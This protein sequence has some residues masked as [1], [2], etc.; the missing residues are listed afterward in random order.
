MK[1]RSVLLALLL[2]VL[3]TVASTAVSAHCI[4]IE[5]PA[6]IPGDTETL[7]TAFYAHPDEAM[8]ERELTSLTLFAAHSTGQ[9]V[10]L[11]LERY[12]NFEQASAVLPVSGQ[13]QLILE[14]EPNRYRMQ[15]IRD[16]GKAVVW[17]DGSGTLVHEPIGASLEFVILEE[18]LADDDST[19]LT[20]A[21]LYNGEP[22][23]DA[24]IEVFQS[25]PGESSLYEEIDELDVDEDGTVTF[26]F[27][28]NASYVLETDHRVPSGEV[29]GTG[30]FIT[31]VRFRSTLFLNL[32]Q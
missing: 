8:A 4:W 22:V 28:P 19:T 32:Q 24:E 17:V 12:T 10:E 6:T 9:V 26:T 5:S 16:F 30:L 11:P 2:L 31:E 25:V 18:E 27:A 7:F 20:F 21:V 13:W 3:M 1:L 14:R 29:E 23:S 15:E